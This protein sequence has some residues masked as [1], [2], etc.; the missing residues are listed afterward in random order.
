M[1]GWGGRGRGALLLTCSCYSQADG[2][3]PAPLGQP[4]TLPLSGQ[5][6]IRVTT[7]K[8]STWPLSP[9]AGTLSRFSADKVTHLLRNA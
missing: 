7:G 1:R 6:G 8:C 9:A 2:R 5:V 3:R 4:P